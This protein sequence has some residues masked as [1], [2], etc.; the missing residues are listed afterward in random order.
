M[1]NLNG[2]F[3]YQTQWAIPCAVLVALLCWRLIAAGRL[4]LA[5]AA[6]LAGGT[7][8]APHNTISDGV[9]FLPLLFW[10]RQSPLPA[11]RAC[12]TFALTPFY[13]FLPAGTLQAI[14]LLLLAAAGY[15][16]RLDRGNS[17]RQREADLT[18]APGC[19]S[20]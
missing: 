10:S 17:A 16:L 7:L 9:L 12:A 5:L 18:G 20:T 2:L 11:V 4:E 15:Q 3:H 6:V 8:I 19:V 14:I 1:V 13:A